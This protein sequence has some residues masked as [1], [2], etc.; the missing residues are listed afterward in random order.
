MEDKRKRRFCVSQEIIELAHELNL[1]A[2]TDV[3][4]IEGVF[5]IAKKTDHRAKS[6]KE[7]SEGKSFFR[8]KLLQS[9]KTNTKFI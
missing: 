2:T 3:I 9:K 8:Q 5:Y 6:V 7:F 4:E 1:G